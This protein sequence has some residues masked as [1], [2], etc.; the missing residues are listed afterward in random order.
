MISAPT[1]LSWG[2]LGGAGR[3][4]RCADEVVPPLRPRSPDPPP[5]L[6]LGPRGRGS[7]EG[8]V[9]NGEGQGEGEGE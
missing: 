5:N 2:S 8:G 4:P 7:G 3:R 6:I 1:G 9:V